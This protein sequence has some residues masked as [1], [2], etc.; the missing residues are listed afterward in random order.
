MQSPREAFTFPAWL[1]GLSPNPGLGLKRRLL[2]GREIFQGNMR[3]LSH[4]L[5]TST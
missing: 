1:P 5:K 3:L 4:T 2:A